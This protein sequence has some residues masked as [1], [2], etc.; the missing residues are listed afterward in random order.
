MSKSIR[1]R[2]VLN[3]QNL[4]QGELARTEESN[5]KLNSATQHLHTAKNFCNFISF[6]CVSPYWEGSELNGAENCNKRNW[7]RTESKLSQN[8]DNTKRNWEK[9]SQNKRKLRETKN[10]KKFSLTKSKLDQNWVKTES[11]SQNW[12]WQSQNWIKTEPRLS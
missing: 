12:V 3:C 9:L 11:Y 10:R 8:W 4:Y 6:K 5:A 2:T 7:V 1:C